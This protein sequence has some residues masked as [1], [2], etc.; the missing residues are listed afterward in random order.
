MAKT[1]T[2]GVILRAIWYFLAGC[3]LVAAFMSSINASS[4]DTVLQQQAYILQQIARILIA[5]FFALLALA[6]KTED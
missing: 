3:F 6:V 5:I 2:S 4:V 1:R